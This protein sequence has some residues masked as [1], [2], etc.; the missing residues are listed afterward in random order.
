MQHEKKRAVKEEGNY[1]L[2]TNGFVSFGSVICEVTLFE[3]LFEVRVMVSLA[4][5]L[6]SDDFVCG[7]EWELHRKAAERR[8]PRKNALGRV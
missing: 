5:F 6:A 3:S 1:R 7:V 2:K 4:L 8:F